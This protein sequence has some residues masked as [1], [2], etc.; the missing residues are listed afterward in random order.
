MTRY[1]PAAFV[2]LAALLV[3]CGGVDN[4]LATVPPPVEFTAGGS[5]VAELPKEGTYRGDVAVEHVIAVLDGNGTWVQEGAEPAD[6]SGR[7]QADVQA[8]GT[9]VLRQDGASRSLFTGKLKVVTSAGG[10][11]STAATLTSF[12]GNREQYPYTLSGD[13]PPTLRIAARGQTT[14][15]GRRY[16][17]DRYTFELS[18]IE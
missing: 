10:I 6:G 8:D 12:E 5:G 9:V 16:L 14:R 4:L 13:R 2:L 15:D 3:G 1:A 18:R 11:R 17:F 7:A